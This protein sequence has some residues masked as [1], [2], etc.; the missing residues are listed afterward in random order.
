MSDLMQKAP[1]G[2]RDDE[3]FLREMNMITDHHIRGCH[4]FSS[5]WKDW[6]RAN[7]IEDLPFLHVGLFKKLDLKTESDEVRHERTLQS[8]STSG[9]SSKIHL[10]SFSS[11][12]QSKSSNLIL[13]EFLGDGKAPLLILDTAKSLRQRGVVS[14]KIAAAMSLREFATDMIFLLK[15]E[16]AESMKE[17]MLE[18]ILTE[19]DTMLVYGFSWM[20][21]FAWGRRTFSKTTKDL[22]AGKTIK[23]IHSGGWKKLEAEQVSPTIFESTLL[24]GLGENSLVLDYYG[25]VEQ[26]GIIYPL[27]EAGWRHV[28]NW[29]NVIVRDSYTLEPLMDEVGQLQLLNVISWGAPYHNVLTEDIGIVSDSPCRCGRSGK[30][31][32]LLGRIPKSEVRGCSNV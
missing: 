19:H 10:D 20:L 31:F 5:I 7:K 30:K 22:L 14:A 2:P 6:Q 32:Q 4:E 21:W 29:A 8:S 27:C 16:N 13:K 26:I 18:P 25:L 15:D 17:E 1:Y 3:Q 24:D 28:P 12:L 23:F 11:Q 9:V